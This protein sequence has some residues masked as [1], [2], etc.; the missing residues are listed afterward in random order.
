M[1][2]KTDVFEKLQIIPT[3]KHFIDRPELAGYTGPQ[4]NFVMIIKEIVE[5]AIEIGEEI[6]IFPE[7]YLD[8]KCISAETGLYRITIADNGSGIPKELLETALCKLATTKGYRYRQQMGAMGFGIKGVLGLSTKL[9]PEPIS[10]INKYIGS[11]EFQGY[12]WRLNYLQEKMDIIKKVESQSINTVLPIIKSSFINDA[13]KNK[14]NHG[15]CL[16]FYFPALQYTKAVDEYLSQIHFSHP[17]VQIYYKNPA[18]EV[19]VF[20]RT[21]ENLPTPPKEILPPIQGISVGELLQK[22][23]LAKEKKIKHFLLNNFH[24]LPHKIILELSKDKYF[25]EILNSKPKD[26]DYIGGEKLLE[27][28]RKLPIP[29]YKEQVLSPI[30]AE[31][32]KKMVY[33][34]YGDKVEFVDTVIRKQQTFSGGV[35][36]VECALITLKD[37]GGQEVLR[38]ANKTPLLIHKS[39]CDLYSLIT[40]EIDWRAY[41]ITE[42]TPALFVVHLMATSLPFISV[43]KSSLFLPDNIK[44]EFKLAFW[45]L[46][47]RYSRRLTK[48]Q[49]H[50]Q[51]LERGKKIQDML[52]ALASE[53]TKLADRTAIPDTSSL[54]K[55]I[56]GKEIYE[57]L[58][59][60]GEKK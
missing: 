12:M 14:W 7:I 4:T 45:E 10:M 1:T 49:Q 58:L 2:E 37:Q 53:I 28:F 24:G 54:L 6:R 29:N 56:V 18:R 46:G 59:K 11:K 23:K 17:H 40:E 42:E 57:A 22:C 50:Q 47:R 27:V 5:N 20:K 15:L 43:A 52:K 38:F 33:G 3:L 36:G 55:K 60:E 21:S 30:G 35:F 39:K 26:L 19:V 13:I 48:T 16:E 34:L 31:N 8:V 9:Q 32:I 41:G 25:S 51:S 44:K